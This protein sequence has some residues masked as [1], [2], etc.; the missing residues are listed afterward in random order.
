MTDSEATSKM[1]VDEAAILKSN[2][3]EG[4][5]EQKYE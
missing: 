5:L 3:L 1:S 2:L 4:G